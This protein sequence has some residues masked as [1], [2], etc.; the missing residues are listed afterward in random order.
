[1][2]NNN[3]IEHSLKD[4]VGREYEGLW[5]SIIR[6]CDDAHLISDDYPNPYL[7]VYGVRRFKQYEFENGLIVGY[8][9][10][11]MF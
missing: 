3:F 2:V 8:N 10:E 1:M 6:K 7:D 9:K 5:N 4:S 11:K